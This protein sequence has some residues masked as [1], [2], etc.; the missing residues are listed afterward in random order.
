MT[1]GSGPVRSIA[2]IGDPPCRARVAVRAFALD[3]RL[4]GWGARIELVDAACVAGADLATGLP[5]RLE[6]GTGARRDRAWSGIVVALDRTAGRGGTVRVVDPVG[7]LCGRP[8]RVA[9]EAVA[10]EEAVGRILGRAAGEGAGPVV[11]PARVGL[12]PGVEPR[13]VRVLVGVG[14]RAGSLLDEVVAGAGLETAVLFGRG[15]APSL[16]VGLPGT[17]FG[18]L[19]RGC[20]ASGALALGA[21]RGGARAAPVRTLRAR[22]LTARIRPGERL[23]LGRH[24]VLRVESVEH[25]FGPHGY[26]VQVLAR[27]RPR[28]DPVRLRRLRWV[29]GTVGGAKRPSGALLAP[30]RAGRIPVRLVDTDPP[31]RLPV[32]GRGQA[33]GHAWLGGFAPG[34]RV[35]VLLAGCGSGWVAGSVSEPGSVLARLVAGGGEGMVLGE[36]GGLRILPGDGA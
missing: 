22:G 31:V 19:D 26:A 20:L 21:E 5:L 2:R 29:E 16:V 14:R 8:I 9:L 17:T 6:F 4:G 30:D 18:V 35:A 3:E 12:G 24:G 11:D 10:V 36:R 13:T 28:A 27:T 15:G 7:W 23:D 32:L 25:R 34:D 33:A 1:L